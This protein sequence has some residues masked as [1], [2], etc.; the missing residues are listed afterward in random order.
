M[1]KKIDLNTYP[2]KDHFTMFS[3]M[4][5]PILN[6]S[7]QVD[8]TEWLK[9]IKAEGKPFFLSCMYEV[10]E[11]A[12]EVP[13]LRQRIKDGGIVEYDH[14]ASS[15]TVLAKD[16]SFRFCFADTSVPFDEYLERT[17]VEQKKAECEPKLVDH[18]DVLSCFFMSCIPWF[19]FTELSLPFNDNTFSNPSFTFGKYYEQ[20]GRTLMPLAIQVNHALVDGVHLGKMF[21]KIEER[22]S[23]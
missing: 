10:A 12:N 23:K 7:V 13:Q 1:E 11:A 2:R 17:K 6:V 8:I 3:K 15:Y 14:C 19:S 16:E 20:N 5:N 4:Q 21:T 22:F 9:R 18:E